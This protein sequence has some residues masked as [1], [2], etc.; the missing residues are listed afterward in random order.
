LYECPLLT[1]QIVKM[2]RDRCKLRTEHYLLDYGDSPM[3]VRCFEVR[4]GEDGSIAEGHGPY[5]D[6]GR[7]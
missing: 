5:P 3:L 2:Y 6:D 4:P 7:N 1:E